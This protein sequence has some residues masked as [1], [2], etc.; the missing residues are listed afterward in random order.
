MTQDHIQALIKKGRSINIFAVAILVLL[1][2]ILGIVI[3]LTIGADMTI[4]SLSQ[5]SESKYEHP[6][7]FEIESGFA[8]VSDNDT[9]S[10]VRLIITQEDGKVDLSRLTVM[11]RSPVK[12]LSLVNGTD[13]QMNA[14]S[15]AIKIGDSRYFHIQTINDEDGSEPV[16]ND[17]SDRFELV[18]NATAIQG[19]PLREGQKVD[20]KMTTQDGS[21]VIYTIQ[22]P[23]SLDGK[24]AVEI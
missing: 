17:E 22:L 1:T 2:A 20:L 7:A 12:S 21:V 4:E 11:W 10:E 16:V 18:M 8:S 14:N 24:S 13:R 5:G 23:E 15:E 6:D 3:G 19:K 9:V